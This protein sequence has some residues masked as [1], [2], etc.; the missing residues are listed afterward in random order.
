MCINHWLSP[1]VT[2]LEKLFSCD[3]IG[4]KTSICVGMIRYVATDSH[5]F[6]S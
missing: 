1:K 5:M 4:N 6:W 2:G 3:T